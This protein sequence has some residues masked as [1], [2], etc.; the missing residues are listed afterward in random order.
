MRPVAARA[1][2]TLATLRSL[3][4]GLY[5]RQAVV[6]VRMDLK[7]T[8]F[9]RRGL[10]IYVLAL[11]PCAIIFLHALDYSPRDRLD[12]DVIILAGIF[13]FYYLRLAIFF[14]CMGIFTWLIRGEMVAKT[15]H[16]YLLSPMRREVLL[17]GKYLVGV[18][19]SSIIF[20]TG[21]TL[22]FALMHGHF[23]AAGRQFVF[24]GPGLGHYGM[25]LLVTVLACAG[26]GAMFL[27]LSLLFKNP[28]IPG[29]I[30]LFWETISNVLPAIIQKLSITFYLKNLCPVSVPAEGPF[31]LFTVVAEPVGPVAAV[32]GLLIL[33]A[34]IVA[35]A[36]YRMRT[37]EINYATD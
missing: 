34:V 4:W 19:T 12:Q 29:A 32:A 31:A 16:Y 9:S 27:A 37:I 13:Q 8:L 33:A 35:F 36:A 7:K 15:L 14:G 11:A 23:G 1:V 10:I 20:G 5:L 28:I 18:L 3:P 21:V 24:D 25:Y 6:I 22:A 26:Y 17:A 2:E 30:V